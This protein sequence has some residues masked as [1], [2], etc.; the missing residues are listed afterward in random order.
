[1]NEQGKIMQIRLQVGFVKRK[2][3]LGK[4]WILAATL[5][6]AVYSSCWYEKMIM[7]KK[8]Y[9][10]KC[11]YS[12]YMCYVGFKVITFEVKKTKDT[13]LNTCK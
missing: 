7:K 10:E 13:P 2:L 9:R 12:M 11:V 3:Q 1:M 6:E 4:G 5:Y 8:S